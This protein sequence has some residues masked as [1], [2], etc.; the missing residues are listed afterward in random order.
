V[1]FLINSIQT[2]SWNI[3]KAPHNDE[4]IGAYG[5]GHPPEYI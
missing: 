4:V 5:K 3:G 2:V 1:I